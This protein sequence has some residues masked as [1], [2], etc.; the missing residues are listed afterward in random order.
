MLVLTAPDN[1]LVTAQLN[2][3]TLKTTDDSYVYVDRNTYESAV[4]LNA[5]YRNRMSDLT[6][7]IG[8]VRHPKAVEKF[9]AAMPEPIRILAPF[10]NT[11]ESEDLDT[12]ELEVLV[13]CMH[14][15]SRATDFLNMLRLPEEVRRT[16]TFSDHIKVEYELSWEQFTNECVPY[17]KIHD[18][19]AYNG[20]LSTH[21]AEEVKAPTAEKTFTNTAPSSPAPVP[22]P[23]TAPT[24][25]APNVAVDTSKYE[26]CQ[27]A[28]D[29]NSF[30]DQLLANA[31]A[32]ATGAP[33]PE[34]KKPSSEPAKTTAPEAKSGKGLLDDWDF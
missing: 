13:G 22:A 10:L 27:S 34:E 19:F 6:A 30:L 5:K 25:K 20:K 17:E 23:T 15:L 26:S 7:L 14:V 31:E 2:V 1:R 29:V 28:E 16:V 24:P 3:I 21:K 18:V 9:Y 32:A 33:A 11:V 8:T 12:D 4:I